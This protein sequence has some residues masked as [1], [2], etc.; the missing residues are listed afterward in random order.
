MIIIKVV[1]SSAFLSLI[2]L[3]LAGCSAESSTKVSPADQM[4]QGAFQLTPEWQEINLESPLRTLPHVQELQVLLDMS[5]HEPVENSGMKPFDII[6][7]PFSYKSKEEGITFKPEVVLVTDKGNEF[8]AGVISNGV[9]KTQY[10]TYYFLGYG[11]SDDSKLYFPK[12]AE[13]VLIKVKANTG[14]RV[15]HLHWT[16]ARY[17]QAP[18][19]TWENVLPSK[20][21][22]ID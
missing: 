20:V 13:F 2:L 17:Y 21:V 22:T 1:F 15:E 11:I 16:A 14:I 9:Q 8:K 5:H 19:D 4:I 6:G 10:G 3:L 12:D 18:N 7:H